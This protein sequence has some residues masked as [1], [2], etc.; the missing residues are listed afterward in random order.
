MRSRP[1]VAGPAGSRN[2]MSIMSAAGWVRWSGRAITVAAF[3]LVAGLRRRDLAQIS[4]WR[5]CGQTPG[6]RRDGRIPDCHL[7]AR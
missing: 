3:P 7:T 4:V 6:H 5:G 2:V 1:E